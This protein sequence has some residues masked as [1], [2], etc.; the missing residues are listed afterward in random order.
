MGKTFKSHVLMN[1]IK[2]LEKAVVDDAFKGTGYPEDHKGIEQALR[3]A[4]QNLVKY[5]MDAVL[6]DYADIELRLLARL[7]P[8]ER[9]KALKYANE[10]REKDPRGESPRSGT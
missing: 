2:K 3:K 6:I 10:V 4:R 1:R 8:E 7:T 9:E 5:V